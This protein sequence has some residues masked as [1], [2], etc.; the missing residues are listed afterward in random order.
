M[1]D[2]SVTGSADLEAITAEVSGDGQVITATVTVSGI[3]GGANL[4]GL[5]YCV[6]EGTNIGTAAILK[7]GT[8]ETT[9]ENGDLY[10]DLSDTEVTN[11][12]VLTIVI[13]DYTATPS[14]ASKGAVCYATAAVI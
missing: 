9:D 11:G 7:Q 1:S 8:D 3:N 5:S 13:T 2:S 14:G 6:Y 4:T 10:I 12:T